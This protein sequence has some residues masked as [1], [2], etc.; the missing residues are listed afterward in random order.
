MKRR[1][2]KTNMQIRAKGPS[3][4]RR[5]RNPQIRC[6]Q[7][8]AT[9]SA[10]RRRRGNDMYVLGIAAAMSVT[11]RGPPYHPSPSIHGA[12]FL[13]RLSCVCCPCRLSSPYGSI[14][15][16]TDREKA[17]VHLRLHFSFYFLLFLGR[18]NFDRVRLLRLPWPPPA[19]KLPSNRRPR[20]WQCNASFMKIF[21]RIS[22]EE[23]Y[24]VSK[25]R[26]R[27]EPSNLHQSK[28]LLQSQGGRVSIISK[29]PSIH[30]GRPPWS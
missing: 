10:Q 7:Q 20:D 23:E 28:S 11:M 3:F 18:P 21:P 17:S 29:W 6:T 15:A 25:K 16:L 4:Q 9:A 27:E 26:Q 2:K 8:P 14:D 22:Y 12:S 24:S 19:N 5:Q 13:K 30:N 1:Y